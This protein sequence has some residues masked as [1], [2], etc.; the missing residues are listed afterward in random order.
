[1]SVPDNHPY[2]EEERCIPR[3][4]LLDSRFA[5]RI[6]SDRH[7]AAVFPHVDAHNEVCGYEL[8]NRGGFTGFAPGGRKGIWALSRNL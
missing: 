7:G 2:L 5:G 1:M 8:K 4:V 3:A 6:K